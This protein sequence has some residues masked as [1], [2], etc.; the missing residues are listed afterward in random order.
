ML[1]Q[2]EALLTVEDR[3]RELGLDL[4]AVA[5]ALATYV[6]AVQTGDYAYTSG[7]LPL[8]EGKL[9]KSGK[10]GAQA[11]YV[12]TEEAA[13]L[14]RQ[15][16]LNGLAAI[17]ALVGSLDRIERIVKVT[18]FVASDPSFT[19]Q[20]LVLN[21][22]SELLGSIFGDRGTHARSAVGVAVLPLDAPV[23]VELFVSVKD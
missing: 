8:I 4:P 15:C 6:P 2:Q 23:E 21:G 3:L 12:T 1:E 20:H 19:Q 22:A 17:K 9:E 16:V 7:Q 5:P 11:G 14:A 18:G 13:A 10:V